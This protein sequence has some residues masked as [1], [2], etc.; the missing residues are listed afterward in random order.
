MGH[1][2]IR[3]GLGHRMRFLGFEDVGRGQHV[4]L[5]RR[6]DQLDL[7]RIAHAGFFQVGAEGAVD[8]ADRGEVLDARKAQ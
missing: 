8:E 5:T 3:P 6:A 2:D 7:E 1:D 4:L